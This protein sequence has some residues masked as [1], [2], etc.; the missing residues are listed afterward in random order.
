MEKIN[1]LLALTGAFILSVTVVEGR[2]IAGPAVKLGIDVLVE[3]HADMLKGKS[4]G[5]ITNATGVDG[6]LRSTAD[7]IYGMPDVRLAALFAPEHGIRGGVMGYTEDE[8]DP[9]TG[10][11]VISVGASEPTA[12]ML[13][14]IDILLF[15][16]Q[17]IGS[18]S[19]TYISTMKHCMSA[20]AR[21]NVPFVVLDRPNPMGGLIVDGPVL[22]MK[23]QSVVG[24]GPVAYVHGMTIGEIAQFFNTEMQINCNLTVIRMEGWRRD[25]YWEDTGL[26]WVPTSPHIPEPDSPLYYPVTG[27]IGELSTVSIGVGYT[28]PFKIVGAPWMDAE[29]FTA[30]MN[31]KNLPGVFFQPF[32]FKPF[33]GMFFNAREKEKTPQCNGFRIIITDRK[34]FLPV[35]TSY[36][37]IDALMTEYPGKLSF[38]ISEH[39]PAIQKQEKKK[40]LGMFD[41][42]NG[43]DIIRLQ[44]Q[45]GL[46]AEEIVSGYQPALKEFIETRKKYLLY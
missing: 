45:N 19:Y 42:V 43:T 8:T 10:V 40:M 38:S 41:K 30:V 31:S 37:I 7:I 6:R 3:K 15:D 44:F 46:R 4:V 2:D 11:K 1:L 33:Y 24:I 22:D 20:A 34:K 18:R 17:D 29:K 23:F 12:K 39:L 13:N 27:I 21:Y 35:V 25:M 28:L 9:K 16:I 14:G 5:L 32:Y 36:N 26:A